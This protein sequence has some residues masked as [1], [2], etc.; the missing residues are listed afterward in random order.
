MLLGEHG[1]VYGHPCIVTAVDLRVSVHA[2]WETDDHVVVE[3]PNYPPTRQSVV[4][5]LDILQQMQD[6]PPGTNFVLAAVQQFCRYAGSWRGMRITTRG[7]R[8]S[9]GL[10]SSSAVTVATLGALFHL[11]K[12]ELDRHKIYELAH[13]A[14][15]A[16]QGKGSGFDVASAAYGGTIYFQDEG[17]VIEKLEVPVLPIVIGY[18]GKKVST[19]DLIQRVAGLRDH[20]PDMVDGI[21]SLMAELVNKGRGS[22]LN[23][24]WKEFG[25]LMNIHQG[26]L[27]SLGVGTAQ[28]ARLVY[29]ARKVGAFGA[30][31]SGA[32]GG[33]CMVALAEPGRMD[34]VRQGLTI[35]GAEIVRLK[36]NAEGLR[37]E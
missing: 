33:D 22:L 13:A 23:A 6:Y 15:L 2:Q 28:L 31:L 25:E 14:V 26:L 3:T 7:P 29:A 12:M 18:S 17:R 21:F 37:L 27:E 10:G 1:V 9:F 32:G 24:D 5:S 35:A 11:N 16:V 19:T 34:A 4:V 36:P 30:K 8:R 20:H